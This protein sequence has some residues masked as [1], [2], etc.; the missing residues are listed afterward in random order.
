[1]PG[2]AFCKKHPPDPQQKP[3]NDIANKVLCE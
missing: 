2:D 3:L 1:M